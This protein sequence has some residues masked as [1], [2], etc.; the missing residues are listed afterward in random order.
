M[1]GFLAAL[2][3]LAI[4]GLA[5]CS[6]TSATR[7]P[8]GTLVPTAGPTRAASTGGEGPSP[9]QLILWLTPAFSPT[10]GTPAGDLLAARLDG[11]ERANPGLT[12]EVRVK[13]E[14]GP[15]GLLESLASASQAA[16]DSLP[17]LA[18]LDSV[19]LHDA[20][21]KE[22]IVSLGEAVDT[23]SVLAWYP[24]AAEAA[25][26]EGSLIGMPFAA[27]AQALAYRSDAYPRPP[28]NW[29]DVLDGP[30]PF[31]FPAGDPYAAFTLAQY[32]SL[33]GRLIGENGRP[34]LQAEILSQ[35]LEFYDSAHRSGVLPLS[36][37]Q[38][39]DSAATWAA[40]RDG[41]AQ[42]ATAFFS[43]F[44]AEY[45]PTTDSLQPLPTSDG[46]GTC[47][48]E[49]WSWALVT[50][51]PVRQDLSL[52]LLTWLSDPEFLGEWTQALGLLPSST[53]ALAVWPDGTQTAVASRL[54]TA[55]HARPTAEILATFGPAVHA[56]VDSVLSGEAS[57][58]VA[59]Q[60]AALAIQAP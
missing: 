54:V 5:A 32:L 38:Y 40:V 36:A 55:A 21:L 10:A 26:T 24:F 37:R 49:V 13:D 28:A 50:R 4:L 34:R 42:A 7:T 3:T 17:D 60:A 33:G 8:D 52:R 15:G 56:A 44:L 59:A 47:I 45:D 6:P 18:A 48:A 31:L 14:R 22:L 41:R 29:T 20:A 39:H 9:S 43:T 11:F 53:A 30:S 58:E 23:P 46:A 12:I 25:R 27:D 19:A 1:R 35:V 57:P 51:E 2:A 16:P